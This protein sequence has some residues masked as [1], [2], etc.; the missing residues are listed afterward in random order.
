MSHAIAQVPLHRSDDVIASPSVPEWHLAEDSETLL[1][2]RET[3]AS[4]IANVWLLFY[5][6]ALLVVIVA[7]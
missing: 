7:N 5:A 6:L 1:S 3:R 4:G 2:M